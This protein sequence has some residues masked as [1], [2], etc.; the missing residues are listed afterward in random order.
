[1]PV[2]LKIVPPDAAVMSL[3]P[4]QSCGKARWLYCRMA[5]IS[6]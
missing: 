5:S 1:M 3:R 6:S 2:A 4:P